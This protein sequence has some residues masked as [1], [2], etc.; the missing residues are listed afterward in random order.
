MGCSTLRP[1]SEVSLFP[2]FLLELTLPILNSQILRIN[3]VL[4]VKVSQHKSL[5]NFDKGKLLMASRKRLGLSQVQM[6]QKLNLDSTYLS[7]LENGRREVDEFY[8]QR[9]EELVHDFENTNRFKTTIETF[10]ESVGQGTPSRESCLEYLRQFLET[11]TD[12][13]KLGWTAV[14]LK[15]HFPLDK[16]ARLNSVPDAVAAQAATRAVAEVQHSGVVYGRS[17]KAAST[18]GK[19]SSQ[20]SR[21]GA[22]SDGPPIPPKRAPK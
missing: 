13:A 20:A 7:Q 6:A 16:W 22:E 10:R 21:A 14:E 8:V 11:C 12:A 4:K 17:R 19:I 15:Q 9:A 1:P 3:N 5:T 18:S 2:Y